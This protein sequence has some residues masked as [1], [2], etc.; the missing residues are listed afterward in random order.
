MTIAHERGGSGP[1]L[2]LIHGIG[3]EGRVWKPVLDRLA[4]ER[5][6][7]T[8]DLPGHGAS[9]PFPAST[10]PTAVA[11]AGEVARLLDELGWE[12]PHL[13]GNSLGG[14]VSL[15]LARR[16]RASSVTGLSPAGFTNDRERTYAKATLGLSV[17]LAR[18]GA[19]LLPTVVANPV[20]R[21][22]A[23]GQMVGRPWRVPADE[24]LRMARNLAASPGFDATNE[25]IHSESFAG[26]DGIDV[27]VTI[28]WG[29]RDRLLLPRQSRRAQRMLPGAR[30][31]ILHGC[32]HVPTWDDPELVARVL[33]EG[34][35]G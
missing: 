22:L 20:G 35:A 8:L 27:P 34:S 13:G 31:T 32:G 23:I 24:A 17:R 14:W 10:R 15:E 9:P 4:R 33:L 7:V 2:V 29:A 5:D 6:V 3:S 21:A 28:A 30:R 18:A 1:P 11:L 26:G 16:G 25:A 12:R 19:G